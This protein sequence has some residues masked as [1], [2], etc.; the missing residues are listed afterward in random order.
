M[1]LYN[2]TPNMGLPN[3]IPGIDTGPD[4]AINIQSSLN[5]IDKH[6]HSPGSGVQI[7]QGGINLSGPLPFNGNAAISLLATSFSEQSSFSA[8]NSLWVGTD[9]NLYFNDGAGDPSIQITNGGTVF[10]SSSGISSGTATASFVSSVLVVNA[11]SNTPANIQGGSVLLGNNYVGSYFTTLAPP[12]SM[13]GSQTITLPI[14]PVSTLPLVISASGTIAAQQLTQNQLATP[15]Q[16]ALNPTGAITMYGGASAPGG[17][18]LCDG[19][20]YSRSIYSALFTAIGTAYGVGDGS[21]TFNVP[22]MRGMFPRGV[23]GASANDPDASSRTSINGGNSG[24]N[25]GS[26]QSSAFGSHYHTSS[27]TNGPGLSA[28]QIPGYNQGTS[29]ANVSTNTV[30]GNETR[31]INIYLNFIIKT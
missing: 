10:A 30:G 29:I 4:Y 18:L 19:A 26:V 11:A 20:A 6:N 25:V 5:I 2:S 22:D 7:N 28:P 13:S 1:G 12:S 14:V 3:P 16:Q 17:Y 23:T 27:C 15:V 21:T 8:I 9:G 24:N 31:P